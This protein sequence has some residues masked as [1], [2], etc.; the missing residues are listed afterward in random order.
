M[1]GSRIKRQAGRII[2]Y[3]VR[4]KVHVNNKKRKKKMTG[5]KPISRYLLAGIVWI[6]IIDLS[7]AQ[8]LKRY[9]VRKSSTD[10]VIDGI[11][12]ENVW[13]NAESTSD[14][15]IL[16]DNQNAA[17][18]SCK[19]KMLWDDM[20]LYV[21]FIIEDK[22][23]WATYSDRDDPLYKEDVVEVYID[24]DG[25][26]RNYLEVEVNPL[27]TIFDL[28]LTK[29]WS[30]GGQGDFGWTMAGLETA[31]AVAGT[32]CD[33]SDTD[34]QW[35]CE[36]ALPFESMKFAAPGMN[37]PPIEGESWRFNMYRFD[38][39][40]T[41]GSE[42]EATGWSQTNGGQHEPGRFGAITFSSPITGTGDESISQEN[43]GFE[44]SQNYPNPFNPSTK[45]NY[46]IPADGKIGSDLTKHVVLKVSD[47]LGREIT[48]LVN[49]HKNPGAYSVNFNGEGL[50]SGVYIYH[51]SAG[52][53]YASRKMIIMK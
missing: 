19:A 47:I 28:W 42:G 29:P 46:S 44:L 7:S 31:V 45:I 23:I 34:E 4:Y 15:V 51:L 21:A 20:F 53:H 43:I 12:D 39:S 22:K 9:E 36:M 52:N 1:I 18:S 8:H 38:R 48:T 40:S 13:N 5:S 6:L 11:L 16:G 26:G 2:K 25:D 33:N 3:P 49:E 17:A 27:N 35:I 30:E 24:Q 10:L 37:Y 14:F 32:V 41:S 50:P